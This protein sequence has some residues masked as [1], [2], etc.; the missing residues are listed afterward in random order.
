MD[1]EAAIV[2]FARAGEIYWTAPDC[3]GWFLRG[4]ADVTTIFMPEWRN[5]IL[6]RGFLGVALPGVVHEKVTPSYVDEFRDADMRREF[7]EAVSSRYKADGTDVRVIQSL[8]EQ[9]AFLRKFGTE[10]SRDVLEGVGG[11][12]D[13]WDFDGIVTAKK[14]LRL[15]FTVSCDRCSASVGTAVGLCPVPKT[16][17]EVVELA[18]EGIEAECK[19]A[20][21]SERGTDMEPELVKTP[22]VRGTMREKLAKAERRIKALKPQLN[23]ALSALEKLARE[24]FSSETDL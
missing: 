7:T 19:N 16:T 18:R 13:D 3:L 21:L 11:E 4:F 2:A 8:A 14:R 6:K 23:E 10:H 17:F 24:S 20:T 22:Y 9:R 1:L 5:K 12:E 15:A